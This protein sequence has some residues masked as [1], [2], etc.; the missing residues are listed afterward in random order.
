MP[1]MNRLRIVITALTAAAALVLAANGWAH[2]HVS[3]P[4]TLAKASTVF[5]LA[6]PT[7]KEGAATTRIEFKPPSGFNIDSFVPSPGW[8]RTVQQTGSGEEAVVTKVTW[9]GGH[10]PTGEDAAFPFLAEPASSKTYTFD[11]RQTYS[12]DSV[13]DW[14]G[15]ESSDTPAPTI[16]AESSL[17]GSSNS[18]LAI[19]ALVVGAIGVVLGLVALLAG[20]RRALA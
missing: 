7:E 19:V 14:S 13:V 8:K 5:T 2:A 1:T 12:D 9:V 15:P 11:V 18:T 4:V 16:E 10:V 3:P 20:G 6:V 17:G